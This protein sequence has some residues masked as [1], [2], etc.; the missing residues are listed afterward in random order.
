MPRVALVLRDSQEN[1]PQGKCTLKLRG[2]VFSVPIEDS[3]VAA[4]VVML[5]LR[6][7][8]ETRWYAAWIDELAPSGA[9]VLEALAEQAK[10]AVWF[11]P[12]ERSGAVSTVIPNV[13]RRFASRN[14]DTVLEIASDSPWDIH[15]FAAARSSL[16][17]QYS[18]A[19]T[20][21]SEL[22]AKG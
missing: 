14:R 4:A 21:W 15:H 11:A 6:E 10:L 9:E 13:L 12:P 19:E 8:S 1:A 18:D 20:L 7:E 5:Q 22:K 17:S 2:R 3:T 16:E